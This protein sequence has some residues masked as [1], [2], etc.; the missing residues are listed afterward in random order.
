MNS[1]IEGHVMIVW[2][3]QI[4]EWCRQYTEAYVRKLLAKSITPALQKELEVRGRRK[5]REGEEWCMTVV[6]ACAH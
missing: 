5:G 6:Y 4:R 1:L 2:S 3:F